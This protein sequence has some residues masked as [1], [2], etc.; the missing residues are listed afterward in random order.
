MN[1]HSEVKKFDEPIKIVGAGPASLTAAINLANAG[2][3]VEVY[4]KQ[5]DVGLRFNGDFQGIENWSTKVDA[6]QFFRSI[7]LSINFLCKPFNEY[8]F[9]GPSMKSYKIRTSRP[10]FYLVERG[11]NVVSLDN[12][13]KKL[14]IEAG[15]KFIWNK[16]VDKVSGNMIVGT[17]PAAADVIAKG[18]VFQTSYPN[19]CLGFLDNRLAQKGYAY[20]LVNQ[21]KATFATVLFED[22][23]HIN[24]Y[25]DRAV[26]TLKQVI[27]IDIEQQKE[28]GGYGNFTLNH[29]TEKKNKVLYVGEAA[30]FQDALWGFGLRYAALSGY[31]AAQSILHNKSYEQMCNEKIVPMMQT[32]FA[33]RW[34]FAH[35]GNFGFE[36]ALSRISETKDI[37]E[38]L[39]KQYNP[40]AF[41]NLVFLV[42][43]QWYRS[44]VVD[45]QCL[46]VDCDCI[47]CRHCRE[48]YQY[49]EVLSN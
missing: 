23:K 33:N 36:K 45:K 21:G 47:W 42:A 7:G 3:E 35:L 2:V 13:L 49:K 39:Y 37:I 31:L 6:L 43:R 16:K 27:K 11:E 34:L 18:I 24:S 9:Y 48:D 20:L 40:S 30:G 10:L 29:T 26:D 15:V 41:K 22:F 8:E 14:A 5:S 4:E 1:L 19:T 28:F 12:G 46:H 17:G 38:K 25:F 44:R 32:S